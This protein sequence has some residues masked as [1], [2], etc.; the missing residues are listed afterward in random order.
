[1]QQLQ[2]VVRFV[3]ID[4][5]LVADGLN[6]RRHILAYAMH[7]HAHHTQLELQYRRD[8]LDS[9]DYAGGKRREQ[10]LCGIERVHSA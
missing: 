10:Q 2:P 4:V 1:M 3:G 5:E 7:P 8:S 9:L 6:F